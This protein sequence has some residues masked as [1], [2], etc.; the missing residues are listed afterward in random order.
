MNSLVDTWLPTHRFTPTLWLHIYSTLASALLALGPTPA[1]DCPPLL[2]LL[3]ATLP[4]VV[5]GNNN[6]TN[7][8]TISCL[9]SLWSLGSYEYKFWA[10]MRGILEKTSFLSYVNDKLIRFIFPWEL[11]LML[12]RASLN[13]ASREPMACRSSYSRFPFWYSKL[14]LAQISAL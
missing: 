9:S 8:N 12:A 4:V 5:F 2:L 3:F 10:A 6:N 11:R 13:G 7:I 14:P 1:L